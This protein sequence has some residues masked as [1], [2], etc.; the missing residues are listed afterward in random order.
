MHGKKLHHKSMGPK[1]AVAALAHRVSH[2][3]SHG[4][5]KERLLCDYFQTKTWEVVKSSDIVAAVK[6]TKKLSNY[7]SEELRPTLLGHT[8]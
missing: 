3:M 7:R 2:I 4:G 8:T 5:K 6:E 1:G